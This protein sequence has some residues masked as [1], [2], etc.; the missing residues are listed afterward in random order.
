[1]NLIN[2]MS[3]KI[4]GLSETKITPNIIG[5]YRHNYQPEYQELQGLRELY[6]LTH[7]HVLCLK[8]EGPGGKS[9]LFA[10]L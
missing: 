3:L 5:F 8:L 2:I 10:V 9:R 6:L 7:G 1:M 4:T